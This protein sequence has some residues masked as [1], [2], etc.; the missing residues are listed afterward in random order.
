V[1]CKAKETMIVPK[2]TSPVWPLIFED[3]LEYRSHGTNILEFTE[4]ETLLEVGM[5]VNNELCYEHTQIVKNDIVGSSLVPNKDNKSIWK[6]SQT[7]E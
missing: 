7:I 1:K 6:P 4:V 2:W 3:G 5:N